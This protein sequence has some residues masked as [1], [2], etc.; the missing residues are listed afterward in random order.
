MTLS[1]GGFRGIGRII[2]G[3]L[4]EVG[5]VMFSFEMKCAHDCELLFMQVNNQLIQVQKN[6]LKIHISS[7]REQVVRMRQLYKDGLGLML[8]KN[9]PNQF[10]GMILM[11]LVGK[12]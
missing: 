4:H 5:R 7:L 3:E 6:I 9:F 11:T 8:W 2:N 10:I 1:V 12:N